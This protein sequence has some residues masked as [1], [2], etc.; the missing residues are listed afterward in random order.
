MPLELRS[1]PSLEE[2]VGNHESEPAPPRP[3]R[4]RRPF[5]NTPR[6]T[7]QPV[8]ERYEPAPAVPT[9]PAVPR[10]K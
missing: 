5:D 6:P 8:V 4:P 10:P 7:D 2:C 9:A 3:R 1:V